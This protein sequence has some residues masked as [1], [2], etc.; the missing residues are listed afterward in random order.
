MMT[1]FLISATWSVKTKEDATQTNPMPGV[2]KTIEVDSHGHGSEGFEVGIIEEMLDHKESEDE[3]NPNEGNLG[4]YEKF[5]FIHPKIIMIGINVKSVDFNEWLIYFIL[6][7]IAFFWT[8]IISSGC[9]LSS[10]ICF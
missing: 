5:A 8:F 9:C 3:I 1:L 6:V 10:F 7:C 2:E 4:S